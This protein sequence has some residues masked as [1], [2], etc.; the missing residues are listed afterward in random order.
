LHPVATKYIFTEKQVN[1]RGLILMIK[2]IVILSGVA[3]ITA[4]T[5]NH[6]SSRGIALVGDWDPNKGVISARPREDVVVHEREIVDIQE[7]KALYDRGDVVFLDARP[8]EAFTAG[9]VSG[10]VSMPFEE[11]EATLEEF[12]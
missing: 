9:H 5:V 10:A 4:F 11:A 8:V 12:C 7:V 2:G 6:L 3:M 1:G